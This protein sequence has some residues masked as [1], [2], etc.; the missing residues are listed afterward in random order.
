MNNKK[1]KLGVLVLAAVTV[2]TATAFA[3]TSTYNNGGYEAL[4]Q[5]M[6]S[7]QEIAHPSSTSFNGTFQMLDNGKVIAEM[8]GDVKESLE[9]KEASGNVQI[10]LMGKEQDLSFFKSGEASYLVDKTN[11]K[12]Y[13]MVNMTQ[14]TDKRHKKIKREDAAGQHQMGKS[15]EALIDYLMGDLKSQFELSQ[16]ADGT[17][18]ITLDLN[19]NEIPVP[20]NLLAGIATEDNRDCSDTEYEDGM[21]LAQKEL[22]MGKMPFLKQFSEMKKDMPKLTQDVKLTG[23]FL[24]LNVDQ[25]DQIKSFDVKINTA[26]KDVNGIYHEES[27]LGS[28]AVN[29]INNTSV[30]TFSPDGK[31][32]EIIDA[33][34]FNCSDK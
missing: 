34:D 22:L 18:S 11:D 6:K 33:K 10:K 19:Q 3:S 7:S 21:D 29:D 28:S 8:T 5:V 20:I 32:V 25:N 24:K 4:K 14:D 12:Y 2:F 23:I 1:L 27:F 26:G 30:D 16:N 15:G 9:G 17:R 31:N 13:Q